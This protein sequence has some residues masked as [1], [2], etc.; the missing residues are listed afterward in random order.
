MLTVMVGLISENNQVEDIL[1][2]PLFRHSVHC[3][4]YFL[5]PRLLRDWLGRMR[6]VEI[7]KHNIRMLRWFVEGISEQPFNPR[8]DLAAGLRCSGATQ[9]A[10][11]VAALGLD[12]H[13]LPRGYVRGDEF[14][15]SLGQVGFILEGDVI[16]AS[17]AGGRG[18]QLMTGALKLVFMF[19]SSNNAHLEGAVV[20]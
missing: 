12:R 16:A 7:N 3:F 18:E 4:H 8:T 13:L 9:Y 15:V 11:P 2:P 1:V 10:W 14:G 20:A 19:Q 17:D 5:E 6:K